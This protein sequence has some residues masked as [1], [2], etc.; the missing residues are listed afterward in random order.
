MEVIE[1]EYDTETI[2]LQAESLK[3]CLDHGGMNLFTQEQ[4]DMFY[5]KI[6][7]FISQSDSRINELEEHQK[8]EQD[9][10]DDGFDEED[11]HMFKEEKKSEQQLQTDLGEV[12]GILFKTHKPLCAGLVQKLTSEHLVKLSASD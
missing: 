10:E 9:D 12:I 5:S 3:N 1:D 7:G 2:G 8:E 6:F 11:L 4:F